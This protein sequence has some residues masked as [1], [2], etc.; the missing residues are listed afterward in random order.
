MFLFSNKNTISIHNISKKTRSHTYKERIYSKSE[1]NVV[2]TPKNLIIYFCEFST[3]WRISVLDAVLNDFT[4]WNLSQFL[5][6]S[7]VDA[8][9]F[10]LYWIGRHWARPYDLIFDRG[11]S[12]VFFVIRSTVLFY[13]FYSY[14]WYFFRSYKKHFYGCFWMGCQHFYILMFK[15]WNLLKLVVGRKEWHFD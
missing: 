2:S 8:I 4:S 7:V 15:I 1:K 9:S 6:V 12:F 14:G 13:N 11:L 3:V 10:I 5:P